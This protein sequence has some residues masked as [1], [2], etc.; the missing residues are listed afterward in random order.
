MPPVPLSSTITVREEDWAVHRF[1]RRKPSPHTVQ[2]VLRLLRSRSV[3]PGRKAQCLLQWSLAWPKLLSSV[4]HRMQDDRVKDKRKVTAAKAKQKRAMESAVDRRARLDASKMRMAL[5][6]KEKKAPAKVIV[7]IPA[8][9]K[10]K[11][12]AIALNRARGS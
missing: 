2:T 9:G 12:K 5:V 7:Q 10:A 6:R 1:N 11:A 3:A 8:V 4:A